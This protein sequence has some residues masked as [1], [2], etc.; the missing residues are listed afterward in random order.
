MS[1]EPALIEHCSPTLASLKVG[2]LFSFF[3]PCLNQLCDQACVLTRQLRQKGLSLRIIPAE[4]GR[5]LCYLYRGTHLERILCD[6]DIA[7]FLKKQGYSCLEPQ[8]ALDT[9]CSRLSESDGFPHEVGLFLGYPLPDVIAFIENK[10]RN[11][12]CCGHWKAYTDECG[13]RKLFAKYNKCTEVY[14]RLYVAGR[15]LEQLTVKQ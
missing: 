5:A 10:G 15:S 4:N 9:L 13:A 6:P 12:L 8:D 7:S 11:C 2:S 3:T 14:K 1:L